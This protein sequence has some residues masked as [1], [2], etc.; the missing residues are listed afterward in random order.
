LRRFASVAVSLLVGLVALGSTPLAASAQ[1]ESPSPEGD[2]FVGAW[3]LTSESPSGISQ[4]M[5]TLIDGGTLVFSPRPAASAGDAGAVFISSGHGAWEQTG[6]TSASASFSVFITDAAGNLMWIVTDSVEMTL[7][8]DGDSW[9]GPYS[10]TTADPDGN[11]LGTA[12]G[13]AEATRL[14]LQ[15]FVSPAVIP[16][17][18]A[19]PAAG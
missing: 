15:P 5:L 12:P 4:S 11:V 1:G 2:G 13:T 7:G 18:S 19:S 14:T 8:P 9:S 3:R 17:S 16:A 6:P 10:S